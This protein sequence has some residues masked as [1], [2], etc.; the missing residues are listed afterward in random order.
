MNYKH[1]SILLIIILII[2]QYMQN[3]KLNEKFDGSYGSHCQNCSNKTINQCME[4][5]DCGFCLDSHRN[6]KCVSGDVHGPYNKKK[7]CR[8]WYHNDPYSRVSWYKKNKIK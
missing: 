5:G 1:V 4:C 2:R 8:M 3:N 6:G 7:H